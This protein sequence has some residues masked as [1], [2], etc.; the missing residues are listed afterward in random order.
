MPQ[1]ANQCP[2]KV[3]TK[4]NEARSSENTNDLETSSP[5]KEAAPG[6]AQLYGHE[7]L[8]AQCCQILQVLQKSK[9]LGFPC[10]NPQF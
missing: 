9:I 8:R 5:D 4:A 2:Q 7:G 1:V 10:E 3:V 6:S